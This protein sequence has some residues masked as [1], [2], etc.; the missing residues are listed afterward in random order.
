MNVT[1][2]IIVIFLYVISFK[3]C[4][5]KTATLN[6]ISYSVKTQQTL[7]VEN[8]VMTSVKSHFLPKSGFQFG[9]IV[10]GKRNDSILI[11]GSLRFR[12]RKIYTKENYLF[13][14]D[15][16]KDSVMKIFSQG[17]TGRIYLKEL[18]EYKNG[19]VTKSK[20]Y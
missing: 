14:H 5:Q 7:L 8:G 10:E 18:V 13:N 15:M 16:A 4:A 11:K 12:G 17:K 1:K 6:G 2:L 20:S 9:Y 3:T 19:V